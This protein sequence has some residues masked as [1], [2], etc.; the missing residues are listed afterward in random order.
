MEQVY[1]PPQSPRRHSVPEQ[2]YRKK[3][4]PQALREAIWIHYCG[5]VFQHKCL[6][7]WCENNMPVYDFHAGHDIPESK[8]GSTTIDNLRPICSRCNLSMGDRYTIKEWCETFQAPE[9]KK[10]RRFFSCF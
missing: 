4:I 2:T 9:K 7:K 6:V 8:G 3:S 10:W 5:R 1:Y